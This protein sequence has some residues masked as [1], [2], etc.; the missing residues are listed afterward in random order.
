MQENLGQTQDAEQSTWSCPWAVGLLGRTASVAK[1]RRGRSSFPAFYGI[2]LAWI[3]V[4]G[5]QNWETPHP[6]PEELL[7][8]QPAFLESPPGTPR[9]K[10][11][12]LPPAA[13]VLE[14]DGVNA[15]TV[16]T[17]HTAF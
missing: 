6:H 8:V 3:G 1:I 15:G 14:I 17:Q 5:S 16:R 10:R 12:H 7:L 9:A 2:L 11:T 4:W 13:H